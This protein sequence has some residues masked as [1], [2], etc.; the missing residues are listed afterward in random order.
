MY[1]CVH[2]CVH[3]TRIVRSRSLYVESPLL[4]SGSS[5]MIPLAAAVV[6]RKPLHPRMLKSLRWPQRKQNS[7]GCVRERRVAAST[8]P[9]SCTKCGRK[10][11][12]PN[13]PSILKGA[14]GRR[15]PFKKCNES[16]KGFEA[17]S[18]HTSNDVMRIL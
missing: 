12:R 7:E 3:I 11:T 17:I 14:T 1:I 16:Y 18:Y 13:S 4:C 5:N 10:G 15:T 6:N 8:S 2:I 9:C